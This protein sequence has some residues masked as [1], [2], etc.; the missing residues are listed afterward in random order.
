MKEFFVR[1]LSDPA[2]IKKF[3]VAF[4]GALGVAL[5]EGLLPDTW[6]SWITVLVAFLTS[7]GVYGVPNKEDSPTGQRL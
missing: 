6:G 2:T 5:S 3:V 4:V 1:L 7:I